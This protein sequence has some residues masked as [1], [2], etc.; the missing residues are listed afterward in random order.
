MAATSR[1]HGKLD[2]TFLLNR[3]P[4]STC[5]M[6]SCFSGNIAWHV[7]TLGHMMRFPNGCASFLHSTCFLPVLGPCRISCPRTALQNPTVAVT[8]PPCK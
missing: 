7:Y 1:F 8:L 5:Q 4:L 6:E 2:T 3:Q